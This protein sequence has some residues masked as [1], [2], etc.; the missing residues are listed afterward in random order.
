LIVEVLG[1]GLNAPPVDADTIDRVC[2]DILQWKGLKRAKRHTPP[3]VEFAKT[4][5]AFPPRL[6]TAVLGRNR[7]P[8]LNDQSLSPEDAKELR[9]RFAQGELASVCVRIYLPR[10]GGQ[11][12]VGALDVHLQQ[13]CDGKR[14]DS[15]YIREGM[16]IPRINSMASGR[17]VQALVLVDP[18]PLAKLLGDAEGPAHEVW[19]TKQDRPDAQWTNWKNKVSFATHVVDRLVEFLTPAADELDFDLLSEYF[20]IQQ[21]QGRR[22]QRQPGTDEEG[23]TGLP[24]VVATPKWFRV[25]ERKCGFTVARSKDAPLPAGAAL[26]VSLAYDIPRGDPLK[27]WSPFDFEISKKNGGLMPT[28]EG[29]NAKL[30]QRNIIRLEILSEEFSFAL[31]GFDA[32]RDLYVRIEEVSAHDEEAAEEGET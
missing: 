14:W 3:P 13:R 28:C 31:D 17:G 12:E 23:D 7:A 29:L 1:P 10:R 20:S 24:E 8:E 16:T 6:T 4:C 9:R 2:N 30:L 22:P 25:M 32:H 11:G 26:Q 18:G 21:P 27:H 19:D 5:L 15:Y